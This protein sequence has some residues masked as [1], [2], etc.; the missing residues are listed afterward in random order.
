MVRRR[1]APGDPELDALLD[2]IAFVMFQRSRID[3]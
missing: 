2:T 3:L 1:S